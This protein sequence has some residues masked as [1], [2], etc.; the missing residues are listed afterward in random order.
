MR[1]RTAN[2]EEG[3]PMFAKAALR[4]AQ[5]WLRTRRHAGHETKIW[6]DGRE[7]CP[8]ALEPETSPPARGSLTHPGQ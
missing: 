6:M 8:D 7:L 3:R 4:E 1:E 2:Q 5:E